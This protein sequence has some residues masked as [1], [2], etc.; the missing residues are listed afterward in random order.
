MDINKFGNKDEKEKSRKLTPAEK[1]RLDDFEALSDSM[2]ENGYKRVNLTISIVKA[3]I[4]AIALLVPLFL[5][6]ISSFVLYNEDSSFH[7]DPMEFIVFILVFILLIFVHEGIHGFTWSLFSRNGF[8]DIEFGFMKEYMTPYCTCKVPLKKSQYILGAIMPCLILGILP[9][10]AGVLW[11]SWSMLLMGIIMTDSA[12]GDLMII[13][14]ILR[15]K[16]D[17]K[18]I[19]YIDHPTQGGG[20][21]FEK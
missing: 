11:N 7:Q 4:F 20:V 1:K 13:Y 2:I 5:I 6:G 15:Y 8:K 19:V 9:M 17:A 10:I 16:S 3:N 14:Q 21:V 18:D 12:A